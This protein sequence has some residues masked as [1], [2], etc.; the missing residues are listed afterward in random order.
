MIWRQIAALAPGDND[1]AVLVRAL[2]LRD[3]EARP[4]PHPA[5]WAALGYHGS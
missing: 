3:P 2:R 4:Y 5:D 1:L